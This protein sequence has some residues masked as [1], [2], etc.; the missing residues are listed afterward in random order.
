LICKSCFAKMDFLKKYDLELFAVKAGAQETHVNDTSQEK[1]TFLGKKRT[2]EEAFGKDEEPLSASKLAKLDKDEE[3]ATP[4]KSS[5]TSNNV[6]KEDNGPK[7]CKAKSE[8]SENYNKFKDHN[9]LINL[10]VFSEL[11]CHCDECHS[12]YEASRLGFLCGDFY[13]DWINRVILEE[14]LKKDVE[15]DTEENRRMLDILQT[16]ELKDIQAIKD[17]PMEKVYIV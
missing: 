14:Q 15:E 6:E 4:K 7:E 10:K 17:L 2:H 1:Q 5:H 3:K 16:C 9:L 11:L 12:I 13:D 8:Y